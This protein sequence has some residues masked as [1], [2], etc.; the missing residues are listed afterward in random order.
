MSWGK[1][2]SKLQ[3]K[4]LDEEFE[5]FMNEVVCFCFILLVSIEFFESKTS[6]IFSYSITTKI[7]RRALKTFLNLSRG[8]SRQRK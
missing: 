6:S 3:E 2:K 5:K 4:D 8:D 7:L 1:L